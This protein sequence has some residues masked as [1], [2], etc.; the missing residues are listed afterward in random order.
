MW[1]YVD[2]LW[3]E[4]NIGLYI[5]AQGFMLALFLSI[6]VYVHVYSRVLSKSSLNPDLTIPK[7]V[8]V[9]FYDFF[10]SFSFFMSP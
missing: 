3:E 9:S 10:S 2:C 6:H 5:M 7:V 1:I 8:F 4:K